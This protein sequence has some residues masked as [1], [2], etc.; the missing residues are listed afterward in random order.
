MEEAERSPMV[1]E[2]RQHIE[3]CRAR[4]EEVEEAREQAIKLSRE[5]LK[6][7]REAVSLAHR[8]KPEEA[9]RLAREGLKTYREFT[10]NL[11]EM[12]RSACLSTLASSA[13]E[14]VEAVLLSQLLINRKISG[15]D[16]LGIGC[17]EYLLGLADAALELRRA[18]LDAL[19]RD[20]PER[21][22]RLLEIM[23]SLMDSLTVLIF[24]DAVL[25][26]RHKVDTLRSLIDRTRSDIIAYV[27][28]GTP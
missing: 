12:T 4:L 18:A 16:E 8:G 14:L 24:P 21:A 3:L 15:P 1:S 9:G 10:S 27:G 11:N 22:E 13:Q 25:P 2:I 20:S 19:R 5:L 6:L 28:R 26:I 17:R 23:E 7:A